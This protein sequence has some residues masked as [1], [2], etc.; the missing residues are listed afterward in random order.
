M[1]NEIW[2]KFGTCYLTLFPPIA[3]KSAHDS[4]F[5]FVKWG[6]GYKIKYY[7]ICVYAT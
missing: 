5:T 7:K 2:K 4:I 6:Y 1:R 3:E